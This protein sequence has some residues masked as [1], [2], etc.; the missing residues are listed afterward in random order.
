MGA[1]ILKVIESE[2]IIFKGLMGGFSIL[3]VAGRLRI[4]RENPN[5]WK[6]LYCTVFLACFGKREPLECFH[7]ENR[8]L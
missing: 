3:R 1:G 5:I 8:N 6:K 7:L 2:Y 4:C